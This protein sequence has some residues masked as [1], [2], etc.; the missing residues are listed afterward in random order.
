[1]P[2][3]ESLSIKEIKRFLQNHPQCFDFYPA[4]RKEIDRL[5]K[6]WIANVA[7][8]VIGAPFRDWVK[9]RIN[10]RNQ[11]MATTKN[12]FVQMDPDIYQA[13]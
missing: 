2:Q 6:Q 8:T 3:Y 4:D 11:T 1:M 13:F 5:P 10:E 12:L 9:N 7:A